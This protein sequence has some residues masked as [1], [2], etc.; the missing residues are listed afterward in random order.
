VG[1]EER[2]VGSENRSAGGAGARGGRSTCHTTGRERL[3]HP[4]WEAGSNDS[5][6][7]QGPRAHEP[8]PERETTPRAH[9]RGRRTCTCVSF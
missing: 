1:V 7:K 9:Q 5:T 4:I 8:A 3:C 2:D 6:V